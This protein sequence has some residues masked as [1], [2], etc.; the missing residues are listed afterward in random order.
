MF[1]IFV[2]FVIPLS[3][4]YIGLRLIVPAR[5]G[6]R[7]KILAWLAVLAAL[8]LLNSARYFRRHFTG[9]PLF[10]EFLTLVYTGLGF[11]MLLFTCLVIRDTGLVFARIAAWFKPRNAENNPG[12]PETGTL[13][14]PERRRFLVNSTNL[15]LLVLT[16]GLGGYGIY[17]A[18][19]PP[20]IKQVRVP[21]T[22]LPEDL[23]DLVIVQITDLHTGPVVKKDYVQTVVDRTMALKPDLIVLTGDIVDGSLHHIQGDVAPLAELNAPMGKYFITGNHE[24]YHNV[25]DWVQEMERLEFEVLLN[26]HRLAARG[27]GKLLI[28]GV[29][30]PRSGIYDP[31][32]IPDYEAALKEAPADQVK[33]L[34]AHRPR[35]IFTAARLGF[36]LQLSGH[37]HGGQI[38]PGHFLVKLREPFVS[39]L[40]R[41]DRTWIYVS[42]GTGFWGPPMRIGAPGEIT[43]IRLRKSA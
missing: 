27:N 21:I 12:P 22:N 34:L 38:F 19:R 39:G 4:F 14:D 43:E 25:H 15:G 40:H 23:E 20:R 16:G 26:S 8:L 18:V 10:E 33:L 5:L 11:M 1:R 24:Y 29:P 31:G 32:R 30:D 36:D 17:Q 7:N 13:R 41:V 42:R 3:C 2:L 9:D 28:V 35:S 6:K 37:T